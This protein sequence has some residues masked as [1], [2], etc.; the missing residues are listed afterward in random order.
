[1]KTNAM[2]LLDVSNI[3]YELVTYKINKDNFDAVQIAINNN[4]PENLLYSPV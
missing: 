1:M 2:R 4:I 3:Q